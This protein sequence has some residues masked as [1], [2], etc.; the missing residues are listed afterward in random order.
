MIFLSV[1]IVDLI[2]TPFEVFCIINLQIFM[3]IGVDNYN[4][5]KNPVY[6]EMFGISWRF[7]YDHT[8]VREVPLDKVSGIIM[9]STFEKIIFAHIFISIYFSIFLFSYFRNFIFFIFFHLFSC[10]TACL[11]LS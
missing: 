7:A 10:W 9:I 1:M 4:I 5:L 11:L 3:K 2:F 8:D 6:K